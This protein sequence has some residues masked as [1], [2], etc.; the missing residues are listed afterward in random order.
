MQNLALQTS[1]VST[2]KS[3]DIY[4]VIYITTNLVTGKRY[5][6]QT[7]KQ[8]KALDEYLDSG[9]LMLKAIKKY[10]ADNFSKLIIYEALTEEDLNNKEVFFIKEHQTIQPLGYNIA[11][12]GYKNPM[13]YASEGE[14]Q[15]ISATL[16]E[17]QKKRFANPEARKATGEKAKAYHANNP[18]ARRKHSERLKSYFADNPEARKA[19]SERLKSYYANN[20]EAHKAHGKRMEAYFADPANRKAFCDSQNKRYVSN[21]DAISKRLKAHFPDPEARKAMS[22]RLRE[23]SKNKPLT[24]ICNIA[25]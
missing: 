6:G 11:E 16:S 14:K 22:E 8:G 17:S 12:G 3:Q 23:A 13:K 24:I 18:E 19:N 15:K 1:K 7:I 9:K 5:V 10:G 21:P 25:S 20:P 4:G 2:P